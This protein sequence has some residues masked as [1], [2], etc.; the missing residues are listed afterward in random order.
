MRTMIYFSL[1]TWTGSLPYGRL[2][3]QLFANLGFDLTLELDAETGVHTDFGWDTLYKLGIQD[4]VLSDEE[5]ERL[6]LSHPI[7]RCQLARHEVTYTQTALVTE[8]LIMPMPNDVAMTTLARPESTHRRLLQLVARVG[9][10][11]SVDSSSH[12]DDR[13]SQQSDA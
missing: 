6:P 9:A 2:F 3:I 11:Y 5:L 10:I 4:I 8:C 7:R 1:Y 12:Q 13:G